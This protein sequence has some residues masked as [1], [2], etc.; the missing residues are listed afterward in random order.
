PAP[1][2]VS[3][4]LGMFRYADTWWFSL[5]YSITFGGFVGLSSYFSIFFYDI[6]GDANV[7]GG[8]TKIQVGYLVTITV[9]AGSFFRPIG[10][11]IADRIGGMRF[12]LG[13]FSIIT[14]CA[15]AVSTIPSSFLV[16]LFFTSVMMACLG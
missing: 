15:F 10:G 6:Y 16:M 7:Q 2:K 4:Y 9:I 8:I 13:L 3:D 11:Y 5:F 12:L 14:V 1:K